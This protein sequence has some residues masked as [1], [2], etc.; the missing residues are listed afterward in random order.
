MRNIATLISIFLLGGIMLMMVMT[1][2]GRTNRS[3]EIKSNLDSAVESTVE[4]LKLK[5]TYDINNVYEYVSDLTQGVSAAIDSDS[6]VTV[7]VMNIDKESGLLSVRVEETFIHPNG[8]EGKVNSE[9]TVILNKIKEEEEEVYTVKFYVAQ[10]ESTVYKQCKV[11][12]GDCLP[13]PAIPQMEGMTFIDWISTAGTS[14]SV[15][16]EGDMEFYGTWG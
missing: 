12:K 5:D 15:P 2:D 7:K 14:L 10:G 1:T 13:S 6:K 3:M 11:R 8:N 9:R 16:I 4:Q